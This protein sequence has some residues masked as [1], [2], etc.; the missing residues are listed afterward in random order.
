MFLARKRAHVN[1]SAS[2]FTLVELLV[3]IFIIG[4]L[5]S[6]LLPAV[7]SAREQARSGDCK[8]RIK[9][10]VLALQMFEES[11]SGLPAAAEL[12]AGR[13]SQPWSAHARLL[14]YLEQQNLADLIDFEET[15]EFPMHATAAAT[16]VSTYMC[17]SEINDR[18]RP[19]PTLTY[20]PLNHCV[21]QGRWNV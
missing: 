4:I 3:V 5:V 16:R 18:P 12:P 20:Y 17:P 1:K 10:I 21:N 2:G 13:T 8:N 14:P 9:Q 19:T 7:Q 6:L 11:N 15:P